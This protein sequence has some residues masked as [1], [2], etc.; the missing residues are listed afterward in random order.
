VK[1][2]GIVSKQA[3]AKSHASAIRGIGHQVTLLGGSPT[4]IPPSIDVVICRPA[5]VS[6]QGYNC[7]MAWKRKGGAAI[8]TNSLD[9]MLKALASEGDM[10][11]APT[12]FFRSQD[13]VLHFSSVLGIYGPHLH[14]E[15]SRDIVA[16]LAAQRSTSVKEADSI[17]SSWE[18]ALKGISRDAIRS[19][20]KKAIDRKESNFR[21]LYS[22]RL[23]G[24]VRTYGF[25]VEDT[26]ALAYYIARSELNDA[27]PSGRKSKVKTS[28]VKT[29]RADA[30]SPH[31]PSLVP[32]EPAPVVVA[33]PKASETA[34]PVADPKGEDDGLADLRG[35]LELLLIEMAEVGIEMM[36]VKQDGE[37]SYRR[38]VVTNESGKIQKTW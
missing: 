18:G 35:A 34:V 2:I 26:E 32:V 33:P 10:P 36:S 28:K 17:L 37:F 13:V 27:R 11:M 29:S 19:H 14:D 7:A 12:D 20:C 16:K 30:W 22:R 3:H 25:A 1:H 5:S 24:G 15:R 31:S 21:K 9:A 38:V 6:H 4:T 23:R 8:I